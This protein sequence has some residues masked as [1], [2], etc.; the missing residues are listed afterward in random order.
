MHY[1][2]S[3]SPTSTSL[4]STSTSTSLCPLICVHF[5]F[6]K[7]PL[8]TVYG[9]MSWR[10]VD[11]PKATDL[12]ELAFSPRSHKLFIDAAQLRVGTSEPPPLSESWLAC[13]CA[14]NYNC[15]WVPVCRSFV[16]FR[17][18]SLMAILLTSS[19]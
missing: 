3:Y 5:L 9:T 4:I 8:N 1:F 14:D 2:W 7:S 10:A 17:R 16:I 18:H 11:L 12:R 19:S 6:C 13:T 15:Y